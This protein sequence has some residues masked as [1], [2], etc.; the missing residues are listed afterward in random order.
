MNLSGDSLSLCP[1]WSPPPAAAQAQKNGPNSSTR[2][3]PRCSPAPPATTLRAT[4]M[5]SWGVVWWTL[6]G[7]WQGWRKPFSMQNSM[8]IL[9]SGSWWVSWSATIC[10][11]NDTLK[12]IYMPVFRHP[13]KYYCFTGSLVGGALDGHCFDNADGRLH[14]DLQRP[15]AQ[16]QPQT[17]PSKAT[18]RYSTCF[19]FT[20]MLICTHFRLLSAA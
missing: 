10:Q 5:C 2:R 12:T 9:Q 16:Q 18:A 3:P 15:H 6:T 20:C 8:K 4:V 7:L 19:I 11:P 17:A 14:Q 13:L 1:Q